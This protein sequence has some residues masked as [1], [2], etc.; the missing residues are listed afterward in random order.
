MTLL[1]FGMSGQVARELAHLAPQA[2]LLSRAEVD[3]AEPAAP[4]AAILERS[5][6]AVIN[7]AAWT[8]VDTAETARD[9]AFAVNAEAP[10][11]MAQTCARL[12]IPLVHIS[13]D[14]VFDGQGDM[15]W[16]P[17]SPTA[18]L[19]V[20]GASKL[21]GEVGVRAAAGSHAILRTSWVFSAHGINFLKTMLRLANTR[22]HLT[23]VSD[24]IGGP[25]PARAIAAACLTIADALVADPS[26]SGTYHFT[27]APDVSWA[28]FARAIFSAAGKSVTVEDIP[29]SAY[30]TPAPRP[31]NSRL[32]CRTTQ[33]VFGITRPDWVEG[34]TE[35]LADL[36]DQAP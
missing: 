25:T 24:Q 6:S 2:T 20:Y 32:D 13:T 19:G 30:P 12:N 5:P 3:L 36:A 16:T 10:R 8:A 18:P 27:G 22:D 7:A 29:S 21:A 14:Y 1:V 4:A 23:I 34:I 17:S 35:V 31:K 26:K 33:D 11:T 9:A 28:G 15:P